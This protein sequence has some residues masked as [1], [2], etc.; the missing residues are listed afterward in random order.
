MDPDP[1]H[2][3]NIIISMYIIPYVLYSCASTTV[4]CSPVF[5]SP[6]SQLHGH[7]DMDG[8]SDP[9]THNSLLEQREPL[10]PVRSHQVG[11]TGNGESSVCVILVLSAVC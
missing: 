8:G 10:H 1:L 7:S 3:S 2:C 5:D 11:Y 9:W 4:S 6:S